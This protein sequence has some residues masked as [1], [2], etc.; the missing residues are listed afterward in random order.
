MDDPTE[1]GLF[2]VIEH[3]CLCFQYITDFSSL[4]SLRLNLMRDNGAIGNEG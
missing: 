1:G 2:L 3:L 4:G